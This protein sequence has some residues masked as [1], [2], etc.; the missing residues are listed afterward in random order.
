[1]LFKKCLLIN[2]ESPTLQFYINHDSISKQIVIKIKDNGL[3]IRDDIQKRIFDPFFT[4]REIG[5]GTGLG[6][7]I[8]YYIITENHGGELYTE[9]FNG[10][11]TTFVIKLPVS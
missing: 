9:K 6:L 10:S 1:M 2:I 8:S 4:T 3:G 11:G 7:S 5:T